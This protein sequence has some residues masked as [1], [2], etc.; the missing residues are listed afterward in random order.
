MEDLEVP[1]E[2]VLEVVVQPTLF[3]MRVAL[4]PATVVPCQMNASM[5]IQSTILF[6]LWINGSVV[7][8]GRDSYVDRDGWMIV[9][10]L[11]NATQISVVAYANRVARKTGS[12]NEPYLPMCEC[13]LIRLLY[14]LGER[15]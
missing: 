4:I 8:W 10:N 7:T 14:M 6:Y 1:R 9:D 2:A 13:V 3:Q 5:V 11:T 15:N 12:N